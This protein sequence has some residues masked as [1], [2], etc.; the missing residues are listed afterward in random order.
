MKDGREAD[1]EKKTERKQEGVVGMGPDLRGKK[2]EAGQKD[3]SGTPQHTILMRDVIVALERDGQLARSPL[4][5]RLYEREE[6]Q[7]ADQA[8]KVVKR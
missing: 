5:F 7:K 1:D 4:L 6:R 8:S 3:T 2:R